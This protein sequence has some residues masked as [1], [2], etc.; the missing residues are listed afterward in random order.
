MWHENLSE[1]RDQG[2]A[3]LPSP[4]MER[5]LAA[6]MEG[7]QRA[8]VKAIERLALAHSLCVAGPT[9]AASMA[10]VH[11]AL[12]ILKQV[13]H[14]YKEPSTT[15]HAGSTTLP[16]SFQGSAPLADDG[17]K[18]GEFSSM[19]P[20]FSVKIADDDFPLTPEGTYEPASKKV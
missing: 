4:D 12:T 2:E 11:D 19:G 15:L 8:M 10:A 1:N 20:R 3:T 18:T 14:E 17:A 5:Q 9:F 13:L 7:R 6:I 16:T